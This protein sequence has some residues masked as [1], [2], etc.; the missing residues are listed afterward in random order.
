MSDPYIG[1]IRPFALTYT[2]RGWLACDGSKASLWEYQALF[3]VISNLYGPTDQRSYF[4]L[5]NLMGQATMH[6]GAP[7]PGWPYAPMPTIGHSYGDT[8]VTATLD[9][10]APHTHTVQMGGAA[11]AVAVTD[12]PKLAIAYRP[13]YAPTKTTYPAWSANPP[14]ESVT[15]PEDTISMVGQGVPAAHENRQPF[16]VFRFC[17]AWDGIFPVSN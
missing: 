6:W 2:P 4:T 15:M 13:Y 12:M 17:I 7:Q 3:A 10:F 8:A 5:P 14:D 11:V 1:E 9:N 16:Q